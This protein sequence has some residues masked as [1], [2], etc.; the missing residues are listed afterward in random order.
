MSPR[1]VKASVVV[2]AESTRGTLT[3]VIKEPED[4][5]L[6]KSVGAQQGAGS[7]TR[8]LG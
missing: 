1:G 3:G 7:H 8:L 6:V 4:K 2:A 5:R